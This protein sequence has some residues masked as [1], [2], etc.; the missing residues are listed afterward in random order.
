[1]SAYRPY[2]GHSK[3]NFST[4]P[5]NPPKNNL[6]YYIS[7]P[8]IS[9]IIILSTLFIVETSHDNYNKIISIAR[10]SANMR[11]I[12]GK[13]LRNNKISIFE[14]WM[15]NREYHKQKKKINKR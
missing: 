13:A 8:I 5:N 1:M 14:R 4:P 9:A 15:I 12:I 7:I 6:I 3:P 10:G 2:Y 11:P